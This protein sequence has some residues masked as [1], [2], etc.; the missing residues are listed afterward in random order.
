MIDTTGTDKDHAVGGVVGLNI[1]RKVITLDG[2]NVLL[3]TK[4]CPTK[5]LTCATEVINRVSG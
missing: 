5:C 2:K 4:D 3:W 1:Q